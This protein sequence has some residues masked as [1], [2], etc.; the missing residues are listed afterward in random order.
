MEESSPARSLDP[1]V[2]AALDAGSPNQ[3]LAAIGCGPSDIADSSRRRERARIAEGDADIPPPAGL[4][5][6]STGL[7]QEHL[8][9]RV[10]LSD[11]EA[12]SDSELEPHEPASLPVEKGEGTQTQGPR[13]KRRR[14]RR[15]RRR[16]RTAGLLADA[17]YSPPPCGELE[18]AAAPNARRSPPPRRAPGSSTRGPGCGGLLPG[19]KQALREDALSASALSASPFSAALTVVPPSRAR[20]RMLPLS[21]LRTCSCALLLPDALLPLLG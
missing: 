7:L 18:H 2:L 12:S 5:A 14:V 8:A 6:D 3:L 17:R 9:G 11:S 19:A 15:H 13:R 21:A 4:L 10:A 1:V 20:G 16:K